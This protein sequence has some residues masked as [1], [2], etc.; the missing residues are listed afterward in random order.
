MAASLSPGRCLRLNAEGCY[1][2]PPNLFG[3]KGE[4]LYEN[5]DFHI[6]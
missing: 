1:L 6:G 4:G 2:M 5:A 3:C